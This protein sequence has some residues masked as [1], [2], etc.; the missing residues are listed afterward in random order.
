MTSTTKS[1]TRTTC[2]SY[3]RTLVGPK[4]KE[5]DAALAE[6]KQAFRRSEVAFGTFPTG[7]DNSPLK[8][9][10]SYKNNETMMSLTRHGMT[11]YFFFRTTP[12][13]VLRRVRR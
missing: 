2:R 6:Q 4:L 9:E 5:V 3:K 11:R 10:Y 12:L 8:G 1:S 13:E 7:I